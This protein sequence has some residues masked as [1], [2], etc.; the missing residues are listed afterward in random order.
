MGV[1]L[2]TMGRQR[3][4][5]G[6]HSASGCDDGRGSKGEVA[7][8]EL[9]RAEHRPVGSCGFFLRRLCAFICVHRGRVV[10]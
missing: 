9:I 3:S 1:A 7:R 4:E 2:R 8:N 6:R 10:H 5:A